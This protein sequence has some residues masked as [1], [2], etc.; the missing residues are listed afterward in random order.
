[1]KP[2][3]LLSMTLAAAL[4]VACNAPQSNA[5]ND[6]DLQTGEGVGTAGDLNRNESAEEAADFAARAAQGGMAEIELGQLAQQRA[7]NP[8][9]RAYAEMMVRDHTNAANEL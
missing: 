5:P 3:G 7:Q 1:M 9:V 8:D 2:T 6:R 4:A